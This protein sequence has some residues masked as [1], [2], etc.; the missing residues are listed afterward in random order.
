MY[1]FSA[2]NIVGLT[3]MSGAGKTLAAD[4]FRENG[5][6]VIDCDLL[7]RKAVE[8]N[9]PCLAEIADAFGDGIIT[10]TGTLDRRK[11]GEIIFRD[12]KKRLELNRIIYP[13]VIYLVID[14]ISRAGKR[15]RRDFLID[16]PTLFES[17]ADGLCDNIAAIVADRE[18]CARRITERDGITP[19]QAFDRL[20]S[21]HDEEFFRRNCRYCIENTGTPDEL[22]EQVAN[23]ARELTDNSK[24]ER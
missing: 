21:Q 1:G 12:E 24:K 15:G 17:G 5:Y 11:L 3:G 14:G 6:E 19:E 9:S 13:Y 20:N 2:F 8:K 23:I 4:V 16:A 10:E 7:S 18:I 22:K